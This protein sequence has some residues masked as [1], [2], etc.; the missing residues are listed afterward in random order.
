MAVKYT[1]NELYLMLI[2]K[3]TSEPAENVLGTSRV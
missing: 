3:E 2:T 1:Q